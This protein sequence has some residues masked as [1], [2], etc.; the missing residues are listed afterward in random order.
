MKITIV[1]G[2]FL[3]V[4][5]VAGGAVEKIWFRLAQEFAAAGH[6]VTYL[7]RTW[8]G[9][10]DH[11]IID[12]IRFVRL[13]GFNHTRRLWIN[14]LLDFWWGLRIFRRLPPGD[15]VACNTVALPVY[16]SRFKPS[17][18]R[19][20]VVLGRMPK[21]QSKFYGGVDRL[22]ATSEA[23]RTKVLSEA[24]RLA[25]R[26][27]VFPNP[28]DWALHQ[29]PPHPAAPFTIG[30]VGRMNPE[31][32]IEILLQAAAELARRPGLPPWRIRLVG[33]QKIPEGGG[34]EAYVASLR[35]L[36]ARAGADVTIDPPVYDAV[37][38]AKIYGSVDVFCYP[39]LAEK[40]E[41]LSVAPLE[42]MAA[43]AVPVVSKLDCYNDVIRDRENGL[44]LNHRAVNRVTQLA[45]LFA[46]L[47]TDAAL[48]QRLA[49]QARS[50]AKR[51]DYG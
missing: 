22:A 31:K 5:P 32:G 44:I 43:G 1:N 39:S 28:I 6:E 34:G 33:P 2:F 8:P 24:P 16:L 21:G 26:T 29:Q 25:P 42:G 19:V 7:S 15:I 17:A 10:P 35:D 40:G 47:L 4:P 30:Y 38:L 45:D 13:K 12:G 18:G 27:Q 37:A 9:F 41:G 46:E 49:E 11:E 14:L 48:R 50:D 23:V 3:P 51:F 20:V 36:A